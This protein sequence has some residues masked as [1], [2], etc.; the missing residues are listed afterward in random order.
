MEFNLRIINVCRTCK[1]FK[2][3]RF[4]TGNATNFIEVERTKS[5]QNLRSYYFKKST[6]RESEQCTFLKQSKLLIQLLFH[7]YFTKNK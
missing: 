3:V 2:I 1:R 4:W 7:Y 5:L 6:E